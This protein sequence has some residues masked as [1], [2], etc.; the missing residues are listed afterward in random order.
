MFFIRTSKPVTSFPN[1]SNVR[2]TAAFPRSAGK[3]TFWYTT[4]SV[5]HPEN[6]LDVLRLERFEDDSISA[7]SRAS[8]SVS[9]GEGR[10]STIYS[11]RA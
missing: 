1:R 5:M 10:I 8:R 7:T 2:R 3:G 11:G 4:S 9:V 6:A